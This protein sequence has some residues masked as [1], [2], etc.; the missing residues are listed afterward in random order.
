MVTLLPSRAATT[1]AALHPASSRRGLPADATPPTDLCTWRYSAKSLRALTPKCLRDQFRIL[2]LFSEAARIDRLLHRELEQRVGID[3]GIAHD[4]TIFLIQFVWRM[5]SHE[6][7]YVMIGEAHTKLD[8]V[9]PNLPQA[10]ERISRH[11]RVRHDLLQT[12]KVFAAEFVEQLILVG[13]VDVDGGWRIL[14]LLCH[15]TH[16]DAF[17]AF[18][19]E[20]LPRGIED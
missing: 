6:H 15:L 8:V 11:L 2:Q 5:R 20:Q 9:P 16:G 3:L 13:K 4:L 10:L 14:D 7:E 19:D 1:P 18:A 17:V 12:R